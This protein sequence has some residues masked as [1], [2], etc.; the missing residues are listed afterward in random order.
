MTDID[1]IAAATVAFEASVASGHDWLAMYTTGRGDGWVGLVQPASDPIERAAQVVLTAVAVQ[2]KTGTLPTRAR[3]ILD[4]Y[5]RAYE[6]DEVPADI[7]DA[8]RPKED[9]KASEAMM[10]VEADADAGVVRAGH[11]T[12]AWGDDGAFRWTADEVHWIGTKPLAVT[13]AMDPME[14]A[15]ASAVTEGAQPPDF[16][17][18]LGDSDLAEFG[19][20]IGR[21]EF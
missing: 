12:Y 13:H 19:I 18:G 6:P 7:A 11:R 21:V 1:P 8:P 14:V 10:I 17:T 16:V 20:T 5:V 3:M 2:D 9:P 15:V 4:S